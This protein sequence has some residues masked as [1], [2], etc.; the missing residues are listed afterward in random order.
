MADPFQLSE[1]QISPIASIIAY[2][3]PEGSKINIS[4]AL[5]TYVED[6]ERIERQIDVAQAEM[7]I[8]IRRLHVENSR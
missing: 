6:E 3:T 4:Y 2:A 8:R 1:V 5:Q 7:L